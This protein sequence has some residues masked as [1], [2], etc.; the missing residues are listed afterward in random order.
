MSRKIVIAGGDGYVGWPLSLRLSNL[1]PK[2]KIIILD[3]LIKREIIQNLGAQSIVPIEKINNRISI[4]NDVLQFQNLSFVKL[5]VASPE[6][7][8]F[9]ATEKPDIFYHLGQIPSA[10]YSMKNV[11]QA[12]HTI[13]NNELGN[14]RIVWALRKYSPDCHLIKLG[15]FGEYYSEDLD[16]AE[17]Y[18]QPSYNG[19][20]SIS[21][22]PF[23]READDVYHITKINDSNILS[24][25]CRQWGLRVSEIMQATI[26]GIGIEENLKHSGLYNRF[27]CDHSFG[28]VVNRFVTQAL[29]ERELTVY[30]SGKQRT[31]LMYLNDAIESLAMISKTYP[32]RGQHKIINH[33]SEKDFCI[34][35]IADVVVKIAKKH[36]LNILIK[37]G[38][39][40]RNENVITK[41]KYSIETT[42]VKNVTPIEKAVDEMFCLIKKFKDRIQPEYLKVGN[43]W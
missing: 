12:V 25:A 37:Y 24:M 9:I 26:F 10:P 2:D 34:S 36:N 18:F 8:G 28:T 7:A 5:D 13:S 1:Y 41:K 43:P 21:Q 16:I 27:D 23:P 40:P 17:G 4:A 29:C 14:T 38:D 30:G 15:S 19:R 22:V 31:G 6:I 39:N 32:Q 42:I 33:V 20:K 11:D 35:E 3:N